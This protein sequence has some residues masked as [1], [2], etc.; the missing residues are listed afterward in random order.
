MKNLS[1]EKSKAIAKLRNVKDYKYKS[2]DQLRKI[3]SEP[4]PKISRSEKNLMNQE[5][6]FQSQ[7]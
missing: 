5:T 4:E 6:D 1:L 2:Q 3:L 7:K